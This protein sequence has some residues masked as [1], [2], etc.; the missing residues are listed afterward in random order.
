[1]ETPLIDLQKLGYRVRELRLGKSWTLV[2]LALHSK[3]SKS[4]IS[5]VENGAAGKPNIQYIFS[6]ANALGVTLDELLKDAT[7][8]TPTRH[9]GGNREL[10]PGLAELQ[11][12]LEFKLSDEDLDR[13][14]SIN[15]RGHR[16]RDKEGW[17]FLLETLKML[18]QRKS[19]K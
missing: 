15:F 17:R 11:T 4:Y 12:E 9:R 18:S 1:M 16:P 3:L 6:I 7:A 2:D 8:A 19:Q 14:A 10:P 5:D 13:L